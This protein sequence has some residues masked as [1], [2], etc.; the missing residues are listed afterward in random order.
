VGLCN[1]CCCATACLTTAGPLNL[2][3]SCGYQ[4]LAELNITMRLLSSKFVDDV[5]CLTDKWALTG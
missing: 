4:V 2:Q 5:G 3:A 1:A